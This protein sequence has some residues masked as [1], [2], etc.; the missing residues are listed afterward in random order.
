MSAD[1][2]EVKQV[3]GNITHKMATEEL[4]DKWSVFKGNVTTAL[5][6]CTADMCSPLLSVDWKMSLAKG[7]VAVAME[8]HLKLHEEHAFSTLI[9]YANPSHL[10]A[11]TDM[12]KRGS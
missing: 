12:N 1:T 10:R 2:T 3:D 5:H 9:V 11:N 4:L 8:E 7:A 6:E